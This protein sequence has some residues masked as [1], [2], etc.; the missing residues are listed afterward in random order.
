MADDFLTA[1]QEEA[2]RRKSQDTPD[3]FL[4][5]LEGE[6]DRRQNEVNTTQDLEEVESFYVEQRDA[7]VNPVKED[8]LGAGFTESQVNAFNEKIAAERG[9]VSPAVISA[10]SDEA[11]HPMDPST[12][13]YDGY[14]VGSPSDTVDGEGEIT[15]YAIYNSYRES[16]NTEQ[17][18]LGEYIYNDPATGQRRRLLPPEPKRLKAAMEGT[19]LSIEDMPAGTS[20]ET[21]AREGL[22]DSFTEVAELGAAIGD[23]TV[24]KVFGVDPALTEWVQ[25]NTATTSTGMS[26][27]DAFLKEGLA[28]TVGFFGGGALAKGVTKIGGRAITSLADKTALRPVL[29]ASSKLSNKILQFDPQK[30]AF[31][32]GGAAGTAAVLDSE[33]ETLLFGENGLLGYDAIEVLGVKATDDA[34]QQVLAAR[35]NLLADALIGAGIVEGGL[36]TGGK[37]LNFMNDVSLSQIITRVS[38]GMDGAKQ[39]AVKNVLDEL[40]SIEASS[41]GEDFLVARERLVKLIQENSEI[42]LSDAPSGVDPNVILDVFSSLEADGVVTPRTL[43]KLRGMRTGAATAGGGDALVDAMD[44]PAR[45]VDE[46]LRVRADESFSAGN[47]PERVA[48][49]I[50]AQQA[51]RE[52][53][54]L[55]EVVT[56]ESAIRD[57]DIQAIRNVLGNERFGPIV[58]RVMNTSPS[59]IT[60][61]ADDVLVRLAKGAVDEVT[62]LNATKN[63]LFAAIPEGVEFD[64]A[65]FADDVAR[66]TTDLNAFDD[67]G[68]SLLGTRLISTIRQGFEDAGGIDIKDLGDLTVD[69][70][71]DLSGMMM[72][73][74]VDFNTLYTKVR[75]RI[76]S[77]ADEAY[78]N[79]QTEVGKRLASIRTAIDD[80]VE[81][82]AKNADGEAADA[83]QTA[84]NFYKEDF[85][86]LVRQGRNKELDQA[87]RTNRLDPLDLEDQTEATVKATLTEGTRNNVTQLLDLLGG[88]ASKVSNVDVE[89]YITANIFE[90]LYQTV[91]QGGLEGLDD[92]QVSSLI[93]EYGTQLRALGDDSVLASQLDDFT[94]RI[95]SARGSKDQLEEALE[96]AQTTLDGIK[97]DAFARMIQPFLNKN[98]DDLMATANPEAQLLAFVRGTNGPDQVRTLLAETGDNP[99][100]REGLQNAYFKE[101]RNSL[102]GATETVSGARVFKPTEVRKLLQ[103]E[104]KLTAVGQELFK[105]DESTARLVDSVIQLADRGAAGRGARIIPGMS[106][107]AEVQAYQGAVNRLIYATVGPLNRTGT[108]LRAIAN[109]AADK[110]D[111]TGVFDQAMS[112][113]TADAKEFAR[114][115]EQVLRKERTVGLVGIRV[116]REVADDM[117]RLAVRAGLYTQAEEDRD[118]FYTNWE[119]AM[120]GEKLARDALEST[121]NTMYDSMFQLFGEPE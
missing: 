56:L 42:I 53:N 102:M 101:L 73:A 117:F 107:T 8:F 38:G 29:E 3:P 5:A 69:D 24:E 48:D 118:E 86:P 113:V 30:L 2:D 23:I 55:N 4:A 61:M 84:M 71:A 57:N 27:T 19:F 105:G 14:R 45:A 59:Q 32:I 65:A 51:V 35:T 62:A 95:L 83:A 50:V 21:L 39:R 28:L 98:S 25:E 112:L 76:S 26:E 67:T 66:A 54:A 115:A 96:E 85:A 36:R 11:V 75:P 110:A 34:A 109:L 116:D 82:V 97:D 68:K 92:A 15:A 72:E 90:K 22:R 31:E 18:T 58:E 77:L 91:R 80:Q 89:E 41:T 52:Q 108:Q 46:V 17:N 12:D 87:I 63:D 10:S 74:G 100:I 70:L 20:L 121:R 81:W 104:G 93:Q 47:N 1:L 43:T 120:D 37:L 60:A 99:I 79:G 7:G 119:K 44:R 49:T 33:T 6:K 16:P 103:D 78:N 111:I 64:Y 106:G 88:D 94:Q 114:I 9:G 13:M 40:S